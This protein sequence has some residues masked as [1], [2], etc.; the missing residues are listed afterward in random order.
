M[1]HN[2]RYPSAKGIWGLAVSSFGL[3]AALVAGCEAKQ[4]EVTAAVLVDGLKTEGAPIGRVL[5][6]DSKTDPNKLLGRPG[7]YTSKV[8]WAD[9]RY[10]EAA[11]IEGSPPL[12]SV[13]DNTIEVFPTIESAVVRQEYIVKVTSGIPMLTQYIFRE[14]KVLMRLQKDILPEEAKQY[15]TNLKKLTR[16]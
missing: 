4:A 10:P 16:Q 15:E 6:F 12:E 8:A 3:C 14:G 7:Q 2:Q 1:R 13:P 9:T 11:P 5:I